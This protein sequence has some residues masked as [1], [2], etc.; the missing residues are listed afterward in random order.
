MTTNL[1]VKP[2]LPGTAVTIQGQSQ[3][4]VLPG[5]GQT[6]MIPVVGNWGPMGSD[7]TTLEPKTSMQ[8]VD[9]LYG[10]QD[11]PLR[12]AALEGFL[13]QN[14]PGGGGA[15]GIVLYRMGTVSA[16]A[17]AKSLNNTAAAPAIH[18]DAKWKGVFG[19]GIAFVV[20]DDPVTVGN[21]RLR[22]QVGGITVETY[23]YVQTDIQSL[24]D[25]VNARPSKYVTAA[26]APLV[27]GTALA[28]GTFTAVGGNDG[29]AVASGDWLAALDALEF[30]PAEIFAPY[31]LT[32]ES[33][34]ASIFSWMQTM[35]AEMKPVRVVTG[36]GPGETLSAALTSAALVRDEHMVR[37]GV[38]SWYD[39]V[40]DKTLSTSQLAPRIA[41]ILAAR[42]QKSALTRALLGGLTPVGS[43]GPSTDDLKVGAAGGVTMLR[44]VSHPDS[45]V[46]VSWGLTTFID[47]TQQFKPY[48]IWSEPRFIG[49]FDNLIRRIVAWGDANIV[50]NVP[51]NDDTRIAVR[52][53]IGKY[54]SEL[55]TAG[56]ATPGTPYVICDDPADPLLADAIPFEFG[57]RPTRTANFLIG[58]GKVK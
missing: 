47:K 4:R 21:D 12:T 45:Q 49:I 20:D 53:E 39:P 7:L 25:L 54:L 41:G 13:G 11:T 23:V 35:A 29:A 33:V 1:F 51:V 15:S 19:N 43:S 26:S 55:V 14:V 28:A 58:V 9:T 30:A 38:G 6:V 42:G 16:A 44:R 22:V 32:D 37:F 10:G 2:D 36:G 50:G 57:F 46:A 18:F 52:K 3:A 27:T 34:K 17:A 40:V 8:E 56:L 48:E 24:H 31:D 5:A